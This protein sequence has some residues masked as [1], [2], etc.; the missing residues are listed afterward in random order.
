[1]RTT[2][3]Q[4]PIR[5]PTTAL[6]VIICGVF[7]ALSGN[8]FGEL[9]WAI[10]TKYSLSST[11]E[12]E[13]FRDPV[14]KIEGVPVDLTP[15]FSYFLGRSKDR[16]LADWFLIHGRVTQVGTNGLLV[17]IYGNTEGH[18]WG[19]G[20]E[21][22]YLQHY[23]LTDVV[24]DGALVLALVKNV[25]RYRY[26]T[27]LGA[28]ATVEHYD[29]GERATDAEI[30]E[31]KKLHVVKLTSIQTEL[32]EAEK[33]VQEAERKKAQERA[34]IV[35]ERKAAL[36]ARI[37]ANQLK[38]ASNGYATFQLELGK[39]YMSGDGV[40]TNL[41]LARHWLQSACTNHESA[42]SNLLERLLKSGGK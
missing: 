12:K 31:F 23:P 33:E 11:D 14:R 1:M 34:R 6:A 25:G 22:I 40:E 32:A 26:K 7:L 28:I 42:A 38:Q 41:A 5:P 24:V 18:E 36:T 17:R 21:T 9:R 3:K 10:K 2:Q 4:F 35:E 27:V 30:A 20:G 29:Y 39:R 16:T 19:V 37:V 15:L 8:V 13:L